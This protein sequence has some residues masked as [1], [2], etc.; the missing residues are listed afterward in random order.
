MKS[1]RKYFAF[2]LLLGLS[3]SLFALNKITRIQLTP[4]AQ[5]WRISIDTTQPA[6]FRQFGLRA[7]DR[8]V[9]DFSNTAVTRAALQQFH[10]NGPVKRLRS[11]PHGSNSRLVFD[12]TGNWPVNNQRLNAGQKTRYR[13][14]VNIYH[15]SASRSL[16][17]RT[18]T[19]QTHVAPVKSLTTASKPAATQNQYQLKPV[20]SMP[21]LTVSQPKIRDIVVVIDPGHG[22]KDPGATG[23]RGRHEKDVV[24]KI[25]KKLQWMLNRQKGF[26]AVLTRKGDYYL[27]LRQRLN[28]ARKKKGDVFVSIHADAYNNKT[29]N[30]VSVF[31]LSQRGATSEA[32]RWLAE[33]ENR[34]ELMGGVSLADKGNILRSV[35]IDLSQ[36]ATIGASLQMGEQLLLNLSRVARLHHDAVEQ[37]AFVVLKSP[38]IPSLL[39]ETGFMSSRRESAL[40]ATNAYQNKIASAIM[41]GIKQYFVQHPPRGTV[42]AV[43][44]K[45]DFRYYVRPGD[46]LSKL[47]KRFHL[48]SR[49]LAEINSLALNSPLQVGQVLLVPKS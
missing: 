13:L 42:L 31:A 41:R 18:M 10:A 48:S 14:G 35:L 38:D 43:L 9:L 30:G 36:T 46:S 2:V 15:V 32:A 24:L 33:R 22:G 27:T 34:S 17:V 20:L 11:S 37:A 23:I 45:D 39:V 21:Q 19:K 25:A 29:A 8:L 12:L 47:A 49:R 1:F 28:I 3:T 40:L 7:P 26:T 44:E 6:R 16:P 4:H 5:F